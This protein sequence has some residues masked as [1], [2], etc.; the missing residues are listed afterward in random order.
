VSDTR[1]RNLNPTNL[2]TDELDRIAFAVVSRINLYTV[3]EKPYDREGIARYV[4]LSTKSIDRLR[5]TGVLK[6]H[7]FDGLKTAFFFPSEVYQALKKSK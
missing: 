1:E 4:G 7:F 3:V 6:A 5:R 2:S